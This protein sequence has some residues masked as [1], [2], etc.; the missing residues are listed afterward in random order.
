M[1]VH[2]KQNF[3]LSQKKFNK[4]YIKNKRKKYFKQKTLQ[5]ACL[6]HSYEDLERRSKLLKQSQAVIIGGS[7]CG[8]LTSKVLSKYFDQVIV[9]ERND[10]AIPYPGFQ[11]LTLPGSS[12]QGKQEDLN[13]LKQNDNKKQNKR[14]TELK[15]DT[16]LNSQMVKNNLLKYG[17]LSD[18]S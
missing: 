14:N 13:H 2:Y 15:N 1:P 10:Q 5:P 16:Y 18:R 4:I 9:F 8:L 3:T 12:D 11:I 6:V 17:P 7:I